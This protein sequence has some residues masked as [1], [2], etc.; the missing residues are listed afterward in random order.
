[1]R[2]QEIQDN[3]KIIHAEGAGLLT[4][5]TDGWTAT[6]VQLSK[7]TVTRF[8]YAVTDSSVAARVMAMTLMS[9][10]WPNAWAASAI[11]TA[12]RSLRSNS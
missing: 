4:K 3:E 11:S 1:M 2:Q 12:E 5:R 9:S 7:R 10:S 8:A 6:Q